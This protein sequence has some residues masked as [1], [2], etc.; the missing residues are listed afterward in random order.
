MKHINKIL[1]VDRF[2]EIELSGG[3]FMSGEVKL[4]VILQ[5]DYNTYLFHALPMCV[6][7]TEAKY[8]AWLIEHDVNI[9]MP[10]PNLILFDY[11]N[12]G[13]YGLNNMFFSYEF[14]PWGFFY[15]DVCSVLEERIEY[16]QKYVYIM[17]D[18]FYLST[19]EVYKKTHRIHDSLIYGFNHEKQEFY[20]ITDGAKS[21]V[22]QDVVYPYEDVVNGYNAIF[23]D[24]NHQAHAIAFIKLNS[25]YCPKYSLEKYLLALTRYANGLPTD[26]YVYSKWVTSTSI[27]FGVCVYD[28]LVD[29]FNEKEAL[30]FLDFRCVHFL[31]EHK[32]IL[33]KGLYYL[34][35][36]GIVPKDFKIAV[37]KYSMSKDEISKIRNQVL[38]YFELQNQNISHEKLDGLKTK[39]CRSLRDYQAAERNAIIRIIEELKRKVVFGELPLSEGHITIEKGFYRNL[40]NCSNVKVM[41]VENTDGYYSYQK[42]FVLQWPLPVHIKKI[43]FRCKGLAYASINGQEKQIPVNTLSNDSWEYRAITFR[44]TCSSLTL[45]VFTQEDIGFYDLDLTVLEGNI[46]AGKSVIASSCW[47]G[48]NGEPLQDCLALHALTDSDKFWNAQREFTGHEWLEVDF[49]EEI[50]INRI[51]VQ[52][53]KDIAR[54]RYYQVEYF[55]GMNMPKK[56]AEHQGSMEGKPIIHDLPFIRMQ[57]LRLTIT[58]TEP[59]QYGYSE[60]GICHFGA[61]CFETVS[62]EIKKDMDN[63]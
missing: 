1:W 18:E 55:D 12:V 22:L 29:Q 38:K 37:D 20:A 45:D 57:K 56:I 51:V 11:Q 36:K 41:K 32:K 5:K 25:E 53:R 42:R 48:D 44:Q 31:Y 39:I 47:L 2:S 49:G 4:P 63:G 17:M 62:A 26:E 34:I 30:Y 50:T 28:S 8:D 46:A 58:Q 6:L 19:K 21:G 14:L 7:K 9:W 13:V 40:T 3:M 16:Q 15:R 23:N 35:S 10:T 52:E 27:T 54:I 59:D 33:L 24:R 60:P 43:H 61:Y